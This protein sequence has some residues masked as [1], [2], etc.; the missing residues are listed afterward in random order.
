MIYRPVL[1]LNKFHPAPLF[2]TRIREREEQLKE[3]RFAT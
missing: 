2:I 3:E 1:A